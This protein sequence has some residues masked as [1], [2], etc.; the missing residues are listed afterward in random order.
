[1]AAARFYCID[2]KDYFTISSGERPV[3][4]AEI[5]YDA[6][7]GELMRPVVGELGAAE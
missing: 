5:D 6:L 1:M 4:Q 3:G 7:C 2:Y